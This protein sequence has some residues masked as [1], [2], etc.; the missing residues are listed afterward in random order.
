M[1]DFQFYQS[2]ILT[3]Y[4]YFYLSMTLWYFL[5]LCVNKQ[6]YALMALDRLLM[7]T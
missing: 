3:W 6:L 2:H 1:G 5:Q 7:M 4:L